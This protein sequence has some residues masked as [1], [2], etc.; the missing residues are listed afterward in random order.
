VS[1]RYF[2]V[3]RTTDAFTG[4]YIVSGELTSTLPNQP[5]GAPTEE[6]RKLQL[7]N[8]FRSKSPHRPPARV[9]RR[10]HE[11]F[12]NDGQGRTSW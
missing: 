9:S 1:V 7:G 10:R 5:C 11:Q 12:G 8:S 4:H 3:V 6:A 2:A